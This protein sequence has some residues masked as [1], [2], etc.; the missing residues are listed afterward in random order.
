MN[1]EKIEIEALLARGETVQV[2]TNGN[3]M[4]PLLIPNRDWVR[5]RQTDTAELRRGDVVLYR[6]KDSILVLHRIFK[7]TGDEFYLIGDNQIEVEG[8]LKKEQIRG[9]MVGLLR[10]GKEISIESPGYRIYSRFWLFSR[11]I[12]KGIRKLRSK[13]GMETPR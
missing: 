10:N 13:K 2:Q 3:S 5:I 4:Y 11:P 1:P 7:R 8:P 9:K 6:R 12:R